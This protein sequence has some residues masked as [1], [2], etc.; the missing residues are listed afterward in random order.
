MIMT[1]VIMELV[2]L[3]RGFIE[4]WTD[5]VLPDVCYSLRTY[6]FTNDMELTQWPGLDGVAWQWFADA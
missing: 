4:K 3:A 6:E 2:P 1:S 5:R